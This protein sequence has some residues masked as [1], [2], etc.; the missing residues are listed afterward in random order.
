MDKAS[1]LKWA[2]RKKNMEGTEKH[3]LLRD[4]D[5]LLLQIRHNRR[6]FDLA[7]DE[8]LLD[9]LIYEHN[10]L[11]SRYAYLLKTARQEGIRLGRWSDPEMND[12]S[13]EDK[14]TCLTLS[15]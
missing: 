1:G 8:D 10:A 3:P 15:I 7:E 13:E 14:E 5:E 12:A 2:A 11:W 9:A 6:L 4:I